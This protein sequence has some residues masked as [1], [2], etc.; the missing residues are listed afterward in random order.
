MTT[1]EELANDIRT[2]DGN[3]DMSAGAL[4]EALADLGY[5]KTSVVSEGPPVV[6]PLTAYKVGMNVDVLRNYDWLKGVVSSTD[7]LGGNVHV[8][9]ERGPVTIANKNRLRRIA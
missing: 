1:I 4:A 9:T 3:H 8:D 6:L 5:A 2:I 7:A